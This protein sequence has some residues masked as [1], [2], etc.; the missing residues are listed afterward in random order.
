M[1]KKSGND[2]SHCLET[3]Y[4]HQSNYALCTDTDIMVTSL[5]PATRG[6]IYKVFRIE[7]GKEFKVNRCILLDG[8]YD[9]QI[10]DSTK[11]ETIIVHIK[12]REPRDDIE[13]ETI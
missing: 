7:D 10:E 8:Y 13:A 1:M 9:C 12:A 4:K 11:V 6:D 5:N 2:Y 3:S